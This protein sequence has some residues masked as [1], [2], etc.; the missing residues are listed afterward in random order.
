MENNNNISSQQVLDFVKLAQPTGEARDHFTAVIQW[1]FNRELCQ[2]NLHPPLN[3]TEKLLLE[4]REKLEA[5]KQY[6]RLVGCR[7]LEAK[8][9]VEEFMMIHYK[10]TTFNSLS[11]E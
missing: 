6:K 11:N 7:L 1:M 10:V 4:R 8:R 3:D 9:I 2:A 5:V